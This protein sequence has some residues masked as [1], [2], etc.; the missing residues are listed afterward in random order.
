MHFSA[1]KVHFLYGLFRPVF[2]IPLKLQK[3]TFTKFNNFYLF[4]TRF[5]DHL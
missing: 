2:A 4:K 3:F 5:I 1:R